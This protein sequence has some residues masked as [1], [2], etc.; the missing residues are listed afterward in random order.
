MRTA[1]AL[2]SVPLALALLLT[3]GCDGEP[4]VLIRP[5]PPYPLMHPGESVQLVAVYGRGHVV[6]PFASSFQGIYD[7][8]SRP[9]SFTWRS[10]TP[11]VA[12][13]DQDGMIRALSVGVSEIRATAEGVRSRPDTVTVIQTP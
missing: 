7:S 12:T 8:Q 9:E 13:V 2:R 10:S 4:Y 1:R 6:F 5:A 11:A 3:P